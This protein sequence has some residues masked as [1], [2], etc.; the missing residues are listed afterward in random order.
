MQK[1]QAQ[2]HDKQK[3]NSMTKYQKVKIRILVFIAVGLVTQAVLSI[4]S[5]LH[6]AAPFAD[7]P[8]CIPL[9]AE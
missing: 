2:T 7:V 5:F 6:V 8:Y 1:Q 4:G 3:R 9:E